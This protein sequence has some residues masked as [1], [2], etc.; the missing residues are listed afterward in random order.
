MAFCSVSRCRTTFLWVLLLQGIFLSY[1]TSHRTLRSF[2][3]LLPKKEPQIDSME[4]T[5]IAIFYNLF[6]QNEADIQ[7]VSNLVQEQFQWLNS[8]LHNVVYVNS[9]G[10]PLPMIHNLTNA[11]KIVSIGHQTEGNE[12]DTLQ[13]LWEI[14][15]NTQ[16][17]DQMVVYLHSKGSFHP[18]EKNDKFRRFVTRG[19]LSHE[20]ATLPHNC[21]VC[22]S[23]MSPTPHS[24][25]PGNMWLAKCSY[26]QTLLP[27][28]EFQIAM[29]STDN[30]FFGSG[31]YA[32]EHW[33]HSHPSNHP[34]DLY[35]NRDYVYGYGSVPS[36]HDLE[37]NWSLEM[38]PRFSS[39]AYY[40][41]QR[42]R[43]DSPTLE[44]R[45]DEYQRLYQVN[46]PEHDWWGWFFFFL[47]NRHRTT[48]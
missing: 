23:R 11:T 1:H 7:R 40:P 41:C 16:N 17:R 39:N 30:D 38:A 33:V 46:K 37:S 48:S 45:I 19:A 31:R 24:H 29:G 36:I 21:T 8:S 3:P 14:C 34:C 12:I 10:T 26:I 18:S 15:N 35:T 42:C 5:P 4:R 2:L 28:Y 44:H 47:M 27:P 32:A 43:R 22:S 13:K 20:C 9:I 6:V 25:T